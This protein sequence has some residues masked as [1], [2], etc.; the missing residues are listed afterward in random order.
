MIPNDADDAQ[1]RERLLELT[2]RLQEHEA[3]LI[4]RR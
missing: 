2:G 4:E 1:T 3:R